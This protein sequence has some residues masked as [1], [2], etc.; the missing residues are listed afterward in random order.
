MNSDFIKNIILKIERSIK[1][2]VFEDVE[3]A[4]VEL[5]DLSS[6]QEWSSLKETICA[7]LNSDGGIVFC[8]I[9]E[10][11]K[12]YNLSGFNRNNEQRLI[13][14]QNLVFKTDDNLLIDISDFIH[15]DYEQ[16]LDKDIAIIHVKPLS[17]D[18]KYVKYNESYYERKLTGDYKIPSSKINLQKEYKSD[19]EQTKELT[20]IKDLDINSFSLDKINNYINLLNKELKNETLKPELKQAIPFLERKYF[21][22]HNNI[23]TLGLLMFGEEPFRYLEYRVEIDCFFDSSNDISKDKA[24]YQNDVISLMDNAFK[25]IWS[26]INVGRTYREGGMALPEYP[27]ELIREVINNSIAHRD[28]TINNFITI[29]VEPNKYLEI[30]NPGTFK[31]KMK[32]LNTEGEIPIRRLIPGIPESKNPKLASVLK[33]FDKIESKGRGMASL[34]NA[35]LL[36]L[37]DL[38]YYE[39]IADNI[40]L[41]IPTGK[42]LDDEVEHWLKGYNNYIINKLR[43]QVNSEHKQL[44]AYFY[45]SEILNRKRFFTIILSESNNHFNALESLKT[46]GLIL[47]HSASREYAP[48]YILDRELMKIDYNSELIELLSDNFINWE[49][50]AKHVLNIIY[51]YTKYNQEALRAAE[52]TPEVYRLLYGKQVNPKT[53]ESLGRKIRGICKNLLEKNILISDIKNKYLLNFSYNNQNNNTLF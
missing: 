50:D 47:E 10:R 45:K 42:L 33:V 35:A 46:A 24:I 17:D 27:E 49:N 41:K 52:L 37:I 5:K 38:P 20:I 30:K 2:N 53:Y 28:Y 26:H 29:N 34:V 23:T 21:I 4:K 44:L 25:F 7:F 51:R 18:L 16:I 43:N 19:L 1:Q 13:E 39:I 12:K 36:N 40:S 22:S 48:V 32:I 11:D 3:S 31:E 6:G 8:G 14:L 15:Y 9:R